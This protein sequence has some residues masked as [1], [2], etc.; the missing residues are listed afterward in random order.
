MFFSGGTSQNRH[1]FQIWFFWNS[2]R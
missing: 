2:K 1:L